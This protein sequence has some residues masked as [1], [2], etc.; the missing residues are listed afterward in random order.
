[1]PRRELEAIPKDIL[2]K[3]Y[4]AVKSIAKDHIMPEERKDSR[5]CI[6]YYGQAGAGK[7]RLANSEHPGSYQKMCNKWWDGYQGQR[8]IICDD[9]D[10]S[11]KVLGHHF[12]WADPWI[13]F[14]GESK[15]GAISPSYDVFVVTSQYTIDQVF[16]DEATREALHRRFKQVRVGDPFGVNR[17]AHE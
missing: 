6:W 2:V 3:H 9:V 17:S 14:I 15:G 4:H 11:H 1:M 13:P 10:P 7:S 5:K 12:K 16:D 8:T